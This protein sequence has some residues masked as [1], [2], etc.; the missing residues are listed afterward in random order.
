M[1]RQI[2]TAAAVLI[3]AVLLTGCGGISEERLAMREQGIAMLDGGDPLA[4]L[5]LFDDAL[6][7]A[8]KVT[9]FELDV[10]KYRAEAEMMLEDYPA[11]LH[12]YDLLRELDDDRAEY[13]YASAICFA[14][15][16]VP[17]GAEARIKAGDE[18]AKKDDVAGKTAAYKALYSY[19]ITEDMA[20]EAEA[21]S[22]TMEAQNLSDPDMA[23]AL[24]G[25][26]FEAE[27]YDRAVS[28]IQKGLL[29]PEGEKKELYFLQAVSEEYLGNYEEALRLFE[30]YVAEYG[31][32]EAAEHEM[33]FLRTR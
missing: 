18:K 28:Y 19:Y 26:L 4:A 25:L 10:L 8:E 15:E 3:S 30:A 2:R 32:D 24:A 11:A 7:D 13:D 14:R 17:A 12:S 5:E 9:D 33:A 31:P 6:E 29:Y 21:L 20:P 1:K 23:A 22:L 27:D 16:G